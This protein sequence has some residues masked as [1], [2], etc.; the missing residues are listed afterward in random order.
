MRMRGLRNR[1]VSPRTTV[2][3]GKRVRRVVAEHESV[4]SRPWLHWPAVEE[5]DKRD[6]GFLACWRL[7]QPVRL[8]VGG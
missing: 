7:L 1:C 2:Y 8:W 5:V 3:I 6:T 4:V